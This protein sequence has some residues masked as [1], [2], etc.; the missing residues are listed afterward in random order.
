M[1]GQNSVIHQTFI[2]AGLEGIRIIILTA[3]K[4]FSDLET[5]L[6]WGDYSPIR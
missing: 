3:L 4:L 5:F 1:Y 2:N 6:Q